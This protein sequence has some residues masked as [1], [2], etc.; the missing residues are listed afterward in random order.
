MLDDGIIDAMVCPLKSGKEADL[1]VVE[2]EPYHYVAKVYKERK[3]R[4]FKNDAGYREGRKDRNSRNSRALSK[5]T[6]YGQKLA[7]QAWHRAEV[8]ALIRLSAAGAR[9]PRVLAH[10]ERVLIMEMIA[11][12]RGQLAPQLAQVHLSPEG[13]QEMYDMILEQVVLMLLNDLV[14]GDLSPYNVL[15]RGGE[16]VIID[17]PQCVSAAHNQQASAM[18]ERDVHAISRFLGLVN[19]AIRKQGDAAWQIWIEYERGTLTP[20]FRPQ[21]GLARPTEVADVEGLVDFVKAAAEEAELERLAEEGDQDARALLKAAQRRA[22]KRARR[23]QEAKEAEAEAEAAKR[24]PPQDAASEGGGK[25]KRRRR[26]RGR[27]DGDGPRE[28]DAKGDDGQN[29]RDGGRR[30]EGSGKRG[31]RDGGQGKRDGGQGKR[32]GGQGKRDGGQGKR[33]G[34]GE[35]QPV[36]GGAATPSF[37]RRR[38]RRGGPKTD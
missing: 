35:A 36:G 30:G 29:K 27:G 21:V 11:D 24:R 6:R 20:E 37:G 34:R 2:R 16:P 10:H 5:G 28:G 32:D 9:V 23:A 1:F 19:P 3:H 18:L 22:A 14:H 7:E 26:R 25:K 13:A 12:E 4:S 15:V 31:K 8:D 38:R 33:D 17:M